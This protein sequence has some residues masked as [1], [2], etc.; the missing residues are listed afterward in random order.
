MQFQTPINHSGCL[1]SQQRYE[2]CTPNRTE[3]GYGDE[4]AIPAE[5]SFYQ[6]PVSTKGELDYED[7]YG[8]LGCGEHSLGSEVDEAIHCLGVLRSH[9]AKTPN[10]I[11]V[12]FSGRGQHA[13]RRVSMQFD[14]VS[15][16]PQRRSSALGKS[17]MPRRVVSIEYGPSADGTQCNGRK[18]R[19]GSLGYSFGTSKLSSRRGSL[20]SSRAAAAAPAS[21]RH[22][23]AREMPRSA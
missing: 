21:R 1:T 6:E 17:R 13:P 16:S 18:C 4:G 8:D 10:R 15:S 5:I 9:S 23:I 2:E 12:E 7:S 22:S 19:Q 14:T 11:S 3:L 20:H